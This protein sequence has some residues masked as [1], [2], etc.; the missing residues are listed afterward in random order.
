MQRR[1][2]KMR[3][4]RKRPPPPLVYPNGPPP[5]PSPSP[6][7]RDSVSKKT[8]LNCL[9]GR[10]TKSVGAPKG[11][12][13]DFS[14]RLG[15]ESVTVSDDDVREAKR[16]IKGKQIASRQQFY[17]QLER[18]VANVP[19]PR[20]PPDQWPLCPW[21]GNSHFTSLLGLE[22]V[23][24]FIQTGKLPTDTNVDGGVAA[25]T[26]PASAPTTTNQYMK[27][28][29]CGLDFSPVW[30]LVRDAQKQCIVCE[31]CENSRI[32]QALL[33]Q[34]SRRLQSAFN[35]A[36]HQEKEFELKMKQQILDEAI[37]VKG[38][39]VWRVGSSSLGQQRQQGGIY[40]MQQS[41]SSTSNSGGGV[42]Q[43]KLVR[44]GENIGV[45]KALA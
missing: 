20:P 35:Q 1:L 33:N 31:R 19:R 29:N 8:K 10:S 41:S 7:L 24:E 36:S 13:V 2:V 34:H 38:E 4:K 45:E 28:S 43:P 11:G 32:K 22:I 44:G 21:T 16:R 6:S 25:A 12:P 37:R 40:S 14:N 23:V 17:K 18:S 27:C 39:K 30:R 5:P 3:Q 42:G 26:A 9:A 15:R